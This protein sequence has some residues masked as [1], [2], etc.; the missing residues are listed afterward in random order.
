MDVIDFMKYGEDGTATRL[1]KQAGRIFSRL[2]NT[3][4]REAVFSC[5]CSCEVNVKLLL[6]ESGH[7][8]AKRRIMCTRIQL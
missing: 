4:G 7:S 1:E 8:V 3:A 5:V 2:V 6:R